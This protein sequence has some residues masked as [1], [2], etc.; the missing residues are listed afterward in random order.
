MTVSCPCA[1]APLL[2]AN[3]CRGSPIFKN[4]VG[5]E[6]GCLWG[7]QCGSWLTTIVCVST[8]MYVHEQPS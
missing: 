7:K 8:H 6:G 4:Q 3:A 2:Q 1:G 5:E